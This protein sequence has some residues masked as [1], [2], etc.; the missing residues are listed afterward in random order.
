MDDQFMHGLKATP[1]R[2]FAERLR[3]R[4]LRAGD[5]TTGRSPSTRRWALAA[6]IVLGVGLFALPGVRASAQAFL[7]LFR[8]VNFTAVPVDVNRLK[9]LA[10]GGLDLPSLIGQQVEVLE[11]PGSPR[12]VSTLDEAATMAGLPVRLPAVVPPGF[13]VVH[14]E[15]AGQRAAR[16]KADT[17]KL[18]DVMDA[19]GITDLQVPE[20]LDGQLATVRV[21]P[22]VRLT[23]A[24]GNSEVS[25]TQA[26]SPEVTVLAGLDL[27]RLGEIGL[28]IVG[29]DAGAAHTLAQ[30]IDWRGTLV[31]PVPAGVSSF[32][33][34]DVRGSRGLLLASTE[35][36]D[37]ALI[38]STG[39]VV[40]GIGGP[41]NDQGLLQMAVSVP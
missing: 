14:I 29:L 40:F 24:N 38:W 28:R 41:L 27:A 39:G 6:V 3:E 30:A 4:L 23:Y 20:G 33:Q 37:K 1:S 9:G 35:R 19:L 11:D 12:V 2:E 15:V 5:R 32:R 22:I 21:P 26:R 25:F 18:Q 34:V 36:R 8:V 31:V 17:R 16:M 10:T 7:N 13:V